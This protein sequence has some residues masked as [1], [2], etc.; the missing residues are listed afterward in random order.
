MSQNIIPRPIAWIVTESSGVINIAP[1]SYFAPLTSTPPSVVV[2]IG[3]KKDGMPKDTLANIRD[4]KK[5]TICM[6]D[7][8]NLKKMHF[9]SKALDKNISEAKKFDIQTIKKLEDFP[10]MIQDVST[11]FFCEFNQE[12]IIDGSLTIP[13]VLEIKHTYLDENVKVP[14]CRIGKSYAQIGKSLE[15]PVI[16]G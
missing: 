8:S 6:V 2:S 1:F 3:H 12:I 16:I 7:E 11:A 4:T 5:C 10:P 13:L 15:A 14:V 9:S